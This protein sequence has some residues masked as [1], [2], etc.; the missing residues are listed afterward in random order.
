MVNKLKG[1]LRNKLKGW[2]YEIR[3]LPE[4]LIERTDR[5]LSATLEMVVAHYLLSHGDLFFVQIG[6]YD[7]IA[8]DALGPLILKNRWPGILVEPQPDACQRLRETYRNEPQIRVEN[9]AIGERDE[10]RAFYTVDTAGGN[11]PDWAGQLASFDRDVILRHKV[12]IPDLERRIVSRPVKCLTLGS[13]LKSAGAEKVDLLQIDAE[14][15]DAQI[16]RS[17]DFGAVKPAILRYEHRHLSADDQNRTVQLLVDKGYWLSVE[18]ADTLAY[19]NGGS[20][21]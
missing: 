13:L 19:L 8:N 18:P 21:K 2:N 17:I 12:H 11:L 14:G 4:P 15:Y 20:P 1:L 5:R 6:A 16:I 7:G 9:V 10:E 3:R